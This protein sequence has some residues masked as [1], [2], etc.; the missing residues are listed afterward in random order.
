MHQLT[1]I[2]LVAE[3][4]DDQTITVIMIGLA[5]VG[6]AAYVLREVSS[7]IAK[8]WETLLKNLGDFC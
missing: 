1:D 3:E 4:D 7:I 8:I 5:C 6:G 2:S